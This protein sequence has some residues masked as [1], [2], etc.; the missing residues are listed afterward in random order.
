M[1][2]DALE[3][4][5]RDAAEGRAARA[6]AIAALLAAKVAVLLDKGLENGELAR[7]ARPL[8]LDGPDGR[9][10]IAVFT[11]V[12]KGAPWVQREPAFGFALRTDV[13]WVLGITPA[14]A[15]IAVNPGYRFDLRLPADEV[16][17]L[18]RASDA[19]AP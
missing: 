8:S 5:I 14:A 16:Q 18:K 6:D 11:S 17:A 9:P 1:E 2:A 13:R 4:I 7:D 10:V 19:A 15:G 3:R 12:D